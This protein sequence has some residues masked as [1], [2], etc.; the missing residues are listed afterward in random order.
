MAAPLERTWGGMGM[1]M[2]HG[3]IL[4]ETLALAWGLAGFG[5]DI[6]TG[7]GLAVAYWRSNGHTA[8]C[9][10]AVGNHYAL[11][12]LWELQK[13]ELYPSRNFV[14]IF[15]WFVCRLVVCATV[16]WSRVSFPV[17]SGPVRFGF[18]VVVVV[19]SWSGLRSGEV[20]A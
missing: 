5:I 10:V 15:F 2:W 7:S 18:V 12:R 13:F 11:T 20:R 4:P 1:G 3:T 8:R 9:S 6:G 19:D 16:V 14:C 17:R